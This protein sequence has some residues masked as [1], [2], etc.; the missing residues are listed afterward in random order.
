MKR[1][2]EI[3]FLVVCCCFHAKGE[4]KND[5]VSF[6]FGASFTGL[7]SEYVL[8][9]GTEAVLGNSSFEWKRNFG[10]GTFG[11]ETDFAIGQ[12]KTD[13][14]S[15]EYSESLKEWLKHTVLYQADLGAYWLWDV[16]LKNKSWLL[17][18][19]PTLRIDGIMCIH[20]KSEYPNTSIPCA[21]WNIQTGLR[22]Y[23]EYSYHFLHVGA[24]FEIPLLM[25]GHFVRS[26][27]PHGKP[28]KSQE[29]KFC[30]WVTPNTFGGIWNYIHPRA[31]VRVAYTIARSEKVQTNLILQ[32]S[33]QFMYYQLDGDGTY[34]LRHAIS[35]GCAFKF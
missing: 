29:Q 30:F 12:C 34:Y 32:Y 20:T 7:R 33:P 10:N 27:D 14:V 25:T 6:S 3:I 11:L 15:D 9:A 35:M 13:I 22:L 28:W 18:L 19:G 17:E 21:E 26:S 24:D 4:N 16:P 31:D 23:A 1:L 8:P 2:G 5:I